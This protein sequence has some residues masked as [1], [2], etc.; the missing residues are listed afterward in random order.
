MAIVMTKLD[1]LIK[2]RNYLIKKQIVIL[3][4]CIIVGILTPNII[5]YRLE[6]QNGNFRSLVSSYSD[7]SQWDIIRSFYGISISVVFWWIITHNISLKI[8]I[9][10][11]GIKGEKSTIK[12]LEQLSNEYYIYNDIVINTRKGK[13]QIDHVVIGPN[14][15][16]VVET[17]NHNGEIFGA[18]EDSKWVQHKTGRNGGTYNSF[19]YNPAKQVK[20]HVYRLKIGI[21]DELKLNPW[22]Q[23]IVVFTNDDVELNIDS[24][25]TAVLKEN[26]LIKYIK[27]FTNRDSKL[28]KR[29]I[30]Q[31]VNSINKIIT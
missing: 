16:F 6:L 23:P 30:A 7:P 2:K 29:N 4:I 19:F 9:I 1:S 15:V 17:K 5:K 8:R 12:T 24:K 18:E 11:N 27:R 31:I 20:T 21:M 26:D 28:S 22:I 25:I 10:N 13:S 3:L 14:G